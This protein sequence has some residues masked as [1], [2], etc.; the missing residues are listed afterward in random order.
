MPTNEEIHRI[1]HLRSYVRD[2]NRGRGM[3]FAV[4]RKRISYSFVLSVAMKAA[5]IM[6]VIFPIL[7]SLARVDSRESEMLTDADGDLG[8]A[9][10]LTHECC[11]CR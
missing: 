7:L 9:S 4:S 8:N 6:A 5:S 3:G 11:A 2:L 10:G 1:E